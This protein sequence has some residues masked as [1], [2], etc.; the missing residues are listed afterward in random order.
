MFLSNYKKLRDNNRGQIS[1]YIA[2]IVFLFGFGII[3][4]FAVII[5]LAFRTQFTNAG[6][7]VGLVQQTGDR[8]LGALLMYDWI[9]V[10]VL[11]VL[12]IGVGLT[13]FRLNAAPAFFIISILMASFLGLISYFFNYVFAQI[14]SDATFVTVIALFP[15]TLLLCTNFHWIALVLFIIGSITLYAKKERGTLG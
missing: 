2:V 13:S 12:I 8:F 4:L 5:F 6:I 3:N 10:L 7:Y 14:V 9:I 11:I 1:N 15:K